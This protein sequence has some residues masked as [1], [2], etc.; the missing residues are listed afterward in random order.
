MAK[1]WKHSHAR[2]NIL[3]ATY[4][5]N[6]MSTIPVAGNWV[7]LKEIHPLMK[8]RLEAFFADPRIKGKVVVSSGCRTYAN[9]KE[10]YRKYKA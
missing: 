4:K 1:Q 10:L 6:R 5:E 3:G 8:R 7:R 2:Y 9:Q